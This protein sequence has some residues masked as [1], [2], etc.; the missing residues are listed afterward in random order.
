M[1]CMCVKENNT[2]PMQKNDGAKQN[3]IFQVEVM[4]PLRLCSSVYTSLPTHS[5]KLVEYRLQS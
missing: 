3:G 2:G 4:L 5:E 1:G